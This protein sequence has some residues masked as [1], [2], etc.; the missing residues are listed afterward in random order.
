LSVLA[1]LVQGAVKASIVVAV[2]VTG[3]IAL[4]VVLPRM[5]E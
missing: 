3:T 2:A 5:D 1:Q 4:V